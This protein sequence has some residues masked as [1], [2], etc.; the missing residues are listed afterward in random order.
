MRKFD[1]LKIWDIDYK[2]PLENDS[3]F[4]KTVEEIE[5]ETHTVKNEKWV[6]TDGKQIF[7][8]T[9]ME[10]KANAIERS[11]EKLRLEMKNAIVEEDFE[12]AAKI[13]DEIK[14]IKGE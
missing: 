11:I 5:T 7:K 9:V 12:T 1:L 13:R 4:N 3:N 2:F 8:R 6:S 10:S 14:K